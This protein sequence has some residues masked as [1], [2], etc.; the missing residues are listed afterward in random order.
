MSAVVLYNDDAD[1]PDI[2]QNCRWLGKVIGTR[3]LSRIQDCSDEVQ[4][5][6]YTAHAC[7]DVPPSKPW[8]DAKPGLP[9][10]GKPGSCCRYSTE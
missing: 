1:S 2:A 5:I 3:M 9:A 4:S 8:T 10:D 6:A 7:F